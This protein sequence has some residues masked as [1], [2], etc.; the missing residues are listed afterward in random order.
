[1]TDTTRQV[2][3]NLFLQV[4]RNLSDPLLTPSTGTPSIVVNSEVLKEDIVET[5]ASVTSLAVPPVTGIDLTGTEWINLQIDSNPAVQIKV[6]GVT[7]AQTQ[8]FE[9]INSINS[10]L[11]LDVATPG[12]SN[13]IVLTSPTIG[14]GSQIIF[15][16]LSLPVSPSENASFVLFNIPV[17][18]LPVTYLGV[19][20][21]VYT[22]GVDYLVDYAGGN[23]YQ[24]SFS[25][26]PR[27][28]GF[29]SIRAASL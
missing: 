17:V 27:V 2:S 4:A 7:V 19:A 15:N 23:I 22:N 21:A 6:S 10:A 8:L 16:V 1:M 29:Q 26:G 28:S 25:I 3:R 13:T 20:A 18:S 5:A 11:G 12:N 14:K 9:I 24:T